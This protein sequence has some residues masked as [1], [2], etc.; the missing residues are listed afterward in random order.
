MNSPVSLASFL[1]RYPS[2]RD[3]AIRPLALWPVLLVIAIAVVIV[4]ASD[5]T[6]T[7]D[8]HMASPYLQ[9]RMAP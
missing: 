7:P 6:S 2:E 3:R 5:S 8:Q 9:A 1:A 4:W